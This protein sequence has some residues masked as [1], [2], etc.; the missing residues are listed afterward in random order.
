MKAPLAWLQL[1]YEKIRFL[2]ALSG[3]AFAD[4]LMFVQLGFQDALFES[5]VKLHKSFDGDIFLVSPQSNA[6]VTMKPFARR[7]IYQSLA[8]EGVQSATSVSLDF[9]IWKNPTN[10]RTRGLLVFGINPSKN[11][12]NL[13]GLTQNIELIKQKDVY[14]F[15]KMSRE[16]FGK[17]PQLLQNQEMVTTEMEERRVKI[18]GLF[19]LG[20][21]FAAD[22]NL[23]TSDINFHRLFTRRNPDLVDLGVIKLKQGVDLISAKKALRNILPQDVILFSQEE[24]IDFER[25]YWQTSTAIGFIFAMGTGIGF[26]VGTL[27]VYQILYT[28]ISEHLPEYATL[29]A[30]G[31]H[32]KYFIF[33]IFQ[34]AM[35]LAILGYIPG[36][37]IT[38]LLYSLAANATNLPIMMT[39]NRASLVLILTIAMCCV[40]GLISMRRLNSADPA[41]IF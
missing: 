34:E 21:S 37:S 28:D 13:P 18:G 41:D 5:N 1:K 39:V 14:L 26:I 33:V 2:V 35:I 4:L 20:A 22:G 29:K 17:I 23:I 27:I 9:A 24:F 36:I 32:N 25:R 7:R 38:M 15:D 40:S 6:S 16:E 10:R 11:P 31:Y 19:S 3:I 8:I 30:I 12:L